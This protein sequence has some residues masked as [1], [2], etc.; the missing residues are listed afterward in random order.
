MPY[1]I[2]IVCGCLFGLC[3]WLSQK[4][5]FRDYDVSNMTNAKRMDFIEMTSTSSS[6]PSTDD[7]IKV[8]DDSI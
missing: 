5:T 7:M 2:C 4:V 1:L 6:H 3:L 8:A